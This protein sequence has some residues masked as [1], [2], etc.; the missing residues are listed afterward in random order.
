[1]KLSLVRTY[2]S[3][4]IPGMY[5]EHNLMKFRLFFTINGHRV[6]IVKLISFY[7]KF[8]QDEI[9]KKSIDFRI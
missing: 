2:L 9:E 1:M 4:I 6:A 8:I 3:Y 7:A 5:Q